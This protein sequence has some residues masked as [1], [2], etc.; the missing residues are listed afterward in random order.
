MNNGINVQKRTIT[1]ELATKLLQSNEGNRKLSDR[2][3]QFLYSQMVSG[4]WM[5][6]ADTIKIGKTGRLLDGQHRL[7][8]LIKYG[9]P[10]DMFVA[11]GLDEKVFTVLDTG[12]N[13]TASDILSM[14][15]Y[16]NSNNVAGAVRAILLF[17][18]GVYAA[19][20]AGKVGKATNTAI[21]KF[22][23]ENPSI[24]EVISH[25]FTIYRQFRFMSH[26]ALTMLYWVLSKKN[27][28]QCDNFFEKYATG[29][30]LGATSP[31]RHLRERLL[32]DSV[33]KSK[34]SSRDKIALFIFAWNAY[35][36]Q[37]KM[38]QLTLQKDY[39]FPKP[40]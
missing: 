7:Q 27:Q 3:I 36:K 16:K 8:A 14:K 9:K 35:R 19:G 15:G 2:G 34:L 24:H 12:K 13:R 11:E 29:I 26:S 17:N 5:I 32:K 6:T 23:D 18:E 28:I 40:I 38:Q 22:A 10:L 37:T 25:T 33:N 30:D 39:N 1:P 20:K 4:D 31:I 21:L